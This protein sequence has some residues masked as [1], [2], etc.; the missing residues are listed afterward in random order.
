MDPPILKI[1]GLSKTYGK[2]TILNNVNLDIYPGEIVGLIGSSGSG[3]TTLLNSIVGFLQPDEG[4]VMFKD[5]RLVADAER[6][7]YKSVYKNP[8]TVKQMYGFAAQMPSFYE[9]LTVRENLEYF[10]KMYNLSKETLS[11]NIETLLR[12]M[13]LETS[14]ETLGED[15]SGGMERRLDIACSLIHNPRILILDEP[16]ADLDPL[17]RKNISSL[18]KT[19]NSKGTTIMLSSHHLNELETLCD[20]VAIINNKTIAEIGTVEELLQKHS[21]V[22][23]II[24]ESQPGKYDKLGKK[25][26]KSFSKNIKD[27]LVK[28]NELIIRCVDPH[29]IFNELISEIESSKEKIMELKL[30][31]PSLDQI[32]FS[33]KKQVEPKSQK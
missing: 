16:T 7:V 24:I 29:K 5:E 3:K 2:K 10:G 20:K 14:Q 25:L 26:K 22:R 21:K 33:L 9:K 27:Y 13:E 30:I 31:K 8:K 6:T 12:L 28:E 1:S 15:L 17:L 11:S 4:D 19:I 23:E 18:I 32:F